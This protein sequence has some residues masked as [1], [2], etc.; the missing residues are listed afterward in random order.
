ML[1]ALAPEP[2]RRYQS[3]LALA[4]DLE[5]LETNQPILSRPSSGLYHF[6]KLVTRHRIPFAAVAVF[7]VLVMVFGVWMSALYARTQSA[8]RLARQRLADAVGARELAEAEA[9]RAKNATELAQSRLEDADRSHA[10]LE[11]VVDF[12]RN[13]LATIKPR[14][15]G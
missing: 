15:V 2:A 3:A 14:Q 8:E 9:E 11:T 6:R 5:R 7:V 4:E 10:E 13:M 12:H 1:K